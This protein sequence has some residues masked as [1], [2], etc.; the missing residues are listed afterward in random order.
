M[1]CRVCQCERDPDKFSWG[2]PKEVSAGG[3]S[4]FSSWHSCI[5]RV[6]VVVEIKE[7]KEW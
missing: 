3:D 7:A 5:C 1:R 4:E 2:T 6:D